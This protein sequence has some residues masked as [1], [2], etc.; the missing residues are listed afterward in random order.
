M[1]ADAYFSIDASGTRISEPV[2]TGVAVSKPNSVALKVE[3]LLDRNADHAEHH[4]TIEHAV[5]LSVLT[6]KTE[7]ACPFVVM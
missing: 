1:T 6:S 4:Q 5:N 3:R 2:N 7:S